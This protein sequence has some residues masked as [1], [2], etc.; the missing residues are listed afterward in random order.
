MM[1]KEMMMKEKMMKEKMMMVQ[2]TKEMLLVV[3]SCY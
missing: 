3:V 2:R 1:M